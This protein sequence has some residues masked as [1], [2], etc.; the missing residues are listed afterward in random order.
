MMVHRGQRDLCQEKTWELLFFDMK[1]CNLSKLVFKPGLE[2]SRPRYTALP[3]VTSSL[4]RAHSSMEMQKS[5]ERISLDSGG[6]NFEVPVYSLQ[7]I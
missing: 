6:R 2:Y 3:L 7:R 5:P 1:A 4:V